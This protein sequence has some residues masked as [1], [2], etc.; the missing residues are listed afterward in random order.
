MPYL[1][2]LKAAALVGGGLGLM[3]GGPAGS[4]VAITSLIIAKSVIAA[5][6]SRSQD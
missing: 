2:I 4:Y 6:S 1:E 3:I 5:D